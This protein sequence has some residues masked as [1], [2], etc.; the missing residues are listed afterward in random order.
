MRH[1]LKVAARLTALLLALCACTVVA[2]AQE[3]TGGIVG[4]VTDSNGAAV[5]GAT[6]NV[7]DAARKTVVRTVT[8]NDE[9]QYDVRDLPVT[10][11]EVSVEAPNFK[12]HVESGVQVNVGKRRQLD[13]TL[14]VGSVEEVVTVE[15]DPVAVELTNA[16]S[17]TVIS[18]EQARELSLNNRNWVQ[19]ITLAPGVSND[20][21]DQVYVG[22]TN[23]AG[24]ANTMNI[25]VN[26]ARSAQ[27]TYTVD[28]ADVTDRGSNITIQAY[29]SVDSIA[30]FNVQRSLFPAETGRSGGGQINVVTRSGGEEF[31]GTMYEFLRNEKLNANDFISNRSTAPAFGRESN[32]KAKRAPFRYNDYGFTLGG[33]VYVPH[34]GE[35]TDGA[36]K[37]VRGTYF[38]FSEEQRKDRRYPTLAGTVPDLNMRQGIFP[39]DICL[40]ANAPTAATATCLDVLPAGTPLASRATINPVARQYLDLVYSKLPAP[41]DALTR[42]LNYPAS[43]VFDFRQEILRLDHQ[44]NSATSIYYRFENDK[45]PT[46]DPNSLF[47]SGSGLP[48]V[49]TSETN[50][51]GKTHTFQLTQVITPSLVAVG[52]WNYGYGAILS[53]TSGS[54]ALANSPITPP[55]AYA[56]TRDAVPIISGNGFSTLTEFANY[57]NFSYKHNFAGD[58]TWTHG[59][60]TLKSGGQLSYY[61]KN[62]NALAGV[63]QGQFSGFLNTIATSTVQASVLAP[64]VA[65]QDANATRRANFQSFAN[66]LQGNNVTFTQAHFD[67]TADLRQKAIEAYAQDEW[68]F[69]PNLTLYYG[70]RYSYFG[71]PYDRNGRLS[72][73]DPS[74]FNAANAPQVTGA[75]NRIIG[76]GNF[77]NGMIVNAQN[78]Q[79]APNGCVPTA[80]PYGKYVVKAPKADLQPRV[81]L[82]W[83]PFGKGRTSIRTGYGIYYDQVLNGTY[84]QNIGQNPPYQ[85]TFTVSA[86]TI[87]AGTPLPTLSQPVPT[88]FGVGPNASV[89]ALSVRAIQPNWK[90]P[91]MQHWS[92]ELQ[93]QIGDKTVVNVGYFG[94]KGTHL[95]GAF[96]LNEIPPGAALNA[97]CASGANTL[98]TPNV[99]TVP[100]QVAGT[101]FGGTVGGVASTILD[102]IRPYRGYRSIN[103]ITPQFNSNYHSLQVMLARRFAG[104]SQVNAAYTWAKNLTDNQTDRS[105]APENSY[106]IRLDRGRATLDRRHVFTANYIY[107]LPFMKE[108]HGF[109]GKV[110]G[111]WQVTGLVSLQTGLPFTVTTNYD[112]AGLGN[113]P[114]L[115]AGNRPN[116]ICNPNDNAPHT[117]E[118]WF[119]L[120]CVQANPTAAPFS[121]TLGNAGRG[122]VNGPSTKR[123]DFSLF[124]NVRFNERFRLQLRGEVFNIFN[125][126]NFR[127][128]NG[129]TTQGTY[130]Q[131]TSVR[132]PRNIQLGIKFYY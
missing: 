68:R 51:P 20:L 120:S 65:G 73:F 5:K 28:G 75:G 118:Q 96:E 104:S 97:R 89:A 23:P 129:V 70:L 74:L 112:A 115:V 99:V 66:F 19:L 76:T 63:N 86:T 2:P 56:N 44:F 123:F 26:G 18:G 131:V 130:G 36:A 38:F 37:R 7:T 128:I 45:I 17:S 113:I 10:L 98:Q 12:K 13:I 116:L 59:S 124:K 127:A 119:N 22:T 100:C 101:Y 54:L 71:S 64:I 87:P 108:Q 111:G 49:S 32:G 95:I 1:H 4:T 16:S 88:G 79:T 85:E 35:G 81:G 42:A 110:L 83:D 52:R 69:R 132:D 58:L 11:Y 122:I 39:I 8:T 6:I 30:E 33:P 46:V 121:N 48:G 80:S 15:A 29:P 114:A 109:S 117:F 77:C 21:A 3:I 67:Y 94:S 47:A 60:H 27:N 103:M 57:D 41:T 78:V 9:G 72:N 50:S 55:L 106:N 40:R 107:E 24:Q 43:G 92:A 102:Q 14:D 53:N 82:A 105:T 25:S 91:Y 61:R 62:E 126:T 90:D 93:Q 34:F 31:H 125:H 84:E